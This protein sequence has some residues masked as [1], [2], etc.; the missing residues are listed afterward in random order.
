MTKPTDEQ[1]DE[2]VVGKF[3]KTVSGTIMAILSIE[4]NS[5]AFKKIKKQKISKNSSSVHTG[6][7]IVYTRKR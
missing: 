3:D 7:T 6:I 4:L 2:K 1:L 5:K